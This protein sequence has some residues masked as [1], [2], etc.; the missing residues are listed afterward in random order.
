MKLLWSFDIREDPNDNR[1]VD[2]SFENGQSITAEYVIG[3][4]GSQSTIHVSILF[5]ITVVRC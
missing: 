2:V 1:V 3:A 5:D 4:D